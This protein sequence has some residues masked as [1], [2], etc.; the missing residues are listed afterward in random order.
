MRVVRFFAVK[1]TLVAAVLALAACVTPGVN[2]A[3][4]QGTGEQS[5]TKQSKLIELLRKD[6]HLSVQ[7]LK[8]GETILVQMRSGDSFTSDS[9]FP[10]KILEEVL[11]HVFN[12]L[13]SL[14]GKYTIKAVG[15]TSNA[16]QQQTNMQLSERRAMSVAYYLISK[17]FDQKLI[18]FEGKGAQDPIANNDTQEGRDV[19]RRVDLLIRSCQTFICNID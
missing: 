11:D 1:L 4:S 12:S 14:G 8:G 5:S 2:S 16:G 13:T 19:N 15:H 10:S 7:T 6:P 17:G 3:G 18:S 9:I